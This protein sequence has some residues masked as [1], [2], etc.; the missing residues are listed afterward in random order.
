VAKLR[1][2]MP[3]IA[4]FFIANLSAGG[5]LMSLLTGPQMALQ[6]ALM[7]TLQHCLAFIQAQRL[8]S[9]SGL[10]LL[11]STSAA[12]LHTLVAS[13]RTVVASIFA[14]MTADHFFTADAVALRG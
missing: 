3:T 2:E 10:Y 9:T 13:A 7:P 8:S 11:P 12:H 4:S 5:T 1:A 6:I 14:F